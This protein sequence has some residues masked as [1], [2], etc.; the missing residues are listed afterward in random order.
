MRSIVFYLL[1]IVFLIIYLKC[2]AFFN[3]PIEPMYN[4]L[5]LLI[6]IIIIIPL[7]LISAKKLIE[8]IKKMK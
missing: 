7:S 5:I 8:V 2:L 3:F 6:L 1:S 4:I